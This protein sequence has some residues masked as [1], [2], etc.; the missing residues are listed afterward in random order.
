MELYCVFFCGLYRFDS[1]IQFH[2]E[3][4]T[5]YYSIHVSIDFSDL[6]THTRIYKTLFFAL[7]DNAAVEI[8]SGN[9]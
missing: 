8:P 7:T 2:S 5:I 9:S 4:T 6:Y 3:C 1:S